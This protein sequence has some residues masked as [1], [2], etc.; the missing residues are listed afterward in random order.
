VRS[1]HEGRHPQGSPGR[2]A[3]WV[4]PTL[5]AEVAF[6]EWTHD[7]KIRQASF[8]A[9]RTDKSPSEIRRE[10]TVAAHA[11]SRAKRRS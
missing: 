11:R 2:K 7:G 4:K 9:L 8:R 1:D 5:A 10:E 6:S 3:H